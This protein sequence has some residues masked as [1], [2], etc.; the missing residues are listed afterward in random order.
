MS[1]RQFGIVITG[2]INPGVDVDNFRNRVI[3]EIE[4]KMLPDKDMCLLGLQFREF[5]KAKEETND[6]A[7]SDRGVSEGGRSQHAG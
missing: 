5:P 3:Q 2:T 4:A 7:T 1:Q 6:D